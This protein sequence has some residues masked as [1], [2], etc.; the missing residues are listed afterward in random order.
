MICTSGDAGTLATQ[1]SESTNSVLTSLANK[2]TGLLDIFKAIELRVKE[3]RHNELEKD[4]SNYGEYEV[5]IPNDLLIHAFNVYSFRIFKDFQEQLSFA[6]G[7]KF[8]L[9]HTTGSIE[10]FQVSLGRRDPREFLVTYDPITK[11]VDCSCKFFM[12]QGFLCAHAIRVL[13]VKGEEEIPKQYILRRWSK[14]ARLYLVECESNE[15]GQERLQKFCWRT[16]SMREC[17]NLLDH[18]VND[19][20]ARTRFNDGLQVLK[21]MVLQVDLRRV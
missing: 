14:N 10:T 1:R 16:N 3:W 11:S 15:V 6:V 13:D 4:Y 5:A 20:T 8:N 7:A 17:I 19:A 2:Q 21:Q 12:Q 9:V 18:C